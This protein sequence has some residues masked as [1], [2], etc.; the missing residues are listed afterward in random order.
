[1]Q[2]P[3]PDTVDINLSSVINTVTIGAHY[4]KAEGGNIVIMGSSTGLHPMRA[5]DYCK[6]PVYLLQS[7]I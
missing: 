4:L 7:R 5:V 3:S 2:P 1:L 6:C